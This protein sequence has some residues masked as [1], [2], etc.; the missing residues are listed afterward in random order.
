M[1]EVK[2]LTKS[3][4][5]NIAVENI[6]FS[7]KSGEILG[8]LGPNGAGK[9]TTM[10][11]ITGYISCDD[12]TVS[13]DGI[14]MLDNPTEAKKKIGYL[15]E[16]PPLYD[17]M[18]VQGYLEFMFN[19][20][21]IKIPMKKHIN[22]VCSMVKISDVQDRIIR[23][24][25]KGYRQRVGFAQALLGNPPLLILDEPTVGLD[26]E[27]IIEIRKL[28]RELGKKHTIILSSHVLSEVQAVCDKIIVI[29]N[30]RIVAEDFTSTLTQS[31]SATNK[32]I[33]VVEGKYN[34]I[35]SVLKKIDGIKK[36]SDNGEI[37]KGCYEFV[38]ESSRDVR[39]LIFRA[40]SKT[41]Y[42][43]LVMRPIE[44]TLEDTYLNIISGK[45]DTKEETEN[46]STS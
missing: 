34:S 9:S 13:I 16:I 2:N 31:G 26:P 1:I 38:V 40:F 15:P 42:S 33:I 39:R 29:N 35:S 22:E 23:H 12:G 28:I 32:L 27:Q 45:L 3:Y 17:D 37:E 14:D 41:D 10:N 46:V 8:F 44:R 21:H 24:L 7:L 20:K 43:I 6:S 11:I 30:G 18:T 5:K 19:L 25:S 36:I 4:G